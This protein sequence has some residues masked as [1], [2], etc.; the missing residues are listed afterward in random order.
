M[1]DQQVRTLWASMA[2]M[3]TKLSERAERLQPYQG[4][5]DAH[6]DNPR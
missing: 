2:R 5:G 4:R 1:T 6:G 3:W